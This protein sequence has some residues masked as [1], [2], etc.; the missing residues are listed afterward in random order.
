MMSTR[1]SSL[2]TSPRPQAGVRARRA[3]VAAG[4]AVPLTPA[5]APRRRRSQR[6]E[7]A[8]PRTITPQQLAAALALRDL[9]DPAD[10]PH[11]MQLVAAAITDPL[12][13]S[14]RCPVVVHRAGP[15][16]TV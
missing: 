7:P 12:A 15:V 8:M 11:A 9:S 1:S 3:L 10:G 2:F 16:V 4:I 14:W 6:E 5:G 13:R